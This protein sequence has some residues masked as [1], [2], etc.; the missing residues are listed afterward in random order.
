MASPRL[1]ARLGSALVAVGLLGA[2]AAPPPGVVV[3]DGRHVMGT[4]LELTLVAASEV[5]GRE[6]LAELFRIAGD[7]DA[8]LSRHDPDSELSQ[9]NARAGQPPT[10]VAPQLARVLEASVAYSRLTRGSFDVTVGPLVALWQ[11]AARRDRPPSGAELAAV[12]SRVGWENLAV[13]G[14]DRV[15]ISVVGAMQMELERRTFYEPEFGRRHHEHLVCLSCGKILEFIQDEIERL[16]DQV[17]RKHGFRPLSHTLQIQGI[18][19]T[20]RRGGRG[21]IASHG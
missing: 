7:L 3:S 2:C 16:Q 21:E 18:C 5:R 20:C 9:L 17:C 6:A 19:K 8:L 1:R 13:A 4:V 12:R 14:G 15:G 10:R 11:E